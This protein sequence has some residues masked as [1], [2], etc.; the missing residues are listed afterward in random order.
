MPVLRTPMKKR[1]SCAA[2]RRFVAS[3]QRASS[4]WFGGDCNMACP[5]SV[6]IGFKGAGISLVN[7][8]LSLILFR[9]V[10][11]PVVADELRR[12]AMPMRRL[13]LA[14]FLLTVA[15]CAGDCCAQEKAVAE[16]TTR[17]YVVFLRPDP[18][19]KTLAKDEGERIQS[20]HMANI[21]KMAQDGIL[22]AAGP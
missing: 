11:Y 21:R 1:P 2:S 10:F 9:R 17:Y 22:I 8:L 12:Y 6:C 15:L 5:L 14:A 20:A 13:A 3:Q 18:S 19:R 16:G 7:M 4:S